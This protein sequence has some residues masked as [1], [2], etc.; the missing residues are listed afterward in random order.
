MF[1]F[2]KLFVLLLAFVLF[3]SILPVNADQNLTDFING[4]SV[5]GAEQQDGKYR[6]IQGTPYN[7]RLSFTETNQRQFDHNGNLTYTMPTGITILSEQTGSLSA[8]ITDHGVTYTI[9]GTFTIDANGNLKVTFDPKDPN[10]NKLTSSPNAVFDAT[11][12]AQFDSSY[13]SI[14]FSE[15][16]TLDLDFIPDTPGQAS[17]SKQN[18]TLDESTGKITYTVTVVA[19]GSCQN[20][21]VKDSFPANSALT[22]FQLVSVTGNSQ[23]YTGSSSSSGFD[24]TFPSM[25]RGETI[26][27]TYTADV[28]YSKGTNGS[29]SQD[30]LHN[31]VIVKPENGN[32]KTA[33]TTYWGGIRY[34]WTDKLNGSISGTD[35]DTGNKIVD[36]TIK[37]N[38]R[39]LTNAAGDTINDRILD[40]STDYMKYYGTGITVHVYDNSGTE[41]SGSPR[42]VSWS[43]MTSSSDSAWTYTIPASDTTPYSYVINY[44]TIVD[45][46]KVNGNGAAVQ[47]RNTA[48]E[49]TDG[50]NI[51]PDPDSKVE[52]SKAVESISEDKKEITWISTIKVPA[53]GLT[54]AEVV[55]TL[56]TAYFPVSSVYANHYDYYKNASLQISGTLSGESWTPDYTDLTKVKITFY[57]DTAKT[58]PGLQAVDGGHTITIKLTTTVDQDWLSY[59]QSNRGDWTKHTNNIDVNGIKDSATANLS[60]KKIEKYVKYQK[61]GN[62]EYLIFIYYAYWSRFTSCKDH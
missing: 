27:I 17:V 8:R 33:E 36:W 11:F 19:S 22:N 50:I 26:T 20:V 61:S 7:V 38:E 6:V 10:Y 28:D 57:Q 43:D 5:I 37:Y 21:N 41:I 9:A 48:N 55:D 54:K 45:M 25:T 49:D 4:V 39:A 40:D 52:V 42:T 58:T 44:Q 30:Q 62:T 60:D 2:K 13:K 3:A 35:S 29:I 18:S 1:N 47:L 15:S 46:D 12:E 32:E 24:F 53:G 34:K 59:G 51:E 14:K 16:T 56:P 23:T 31:K